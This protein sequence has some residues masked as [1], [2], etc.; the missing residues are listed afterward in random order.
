[1]TLTVTVKS[2]MDVVWE[3][4]ATAVSSKNSQGPFDILP[5]HSNFISV[6]ENQPIVIRIGKEKK[7]FSFP[8]SV[9]Y[10]HS[11]AVEIYTN[12]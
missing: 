6:V 10:A 4:E 12:L 8:F 5:M 11:N 7:E 9:L 1:M 3:G 2:T